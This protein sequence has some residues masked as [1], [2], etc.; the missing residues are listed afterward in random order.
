[1][2]FS[3]DF[4]RTKAAKVGSV[5]TLAGQNEIPYLSSLPRN[6]QS[7]FIR[8]GARR[9]GPVTTVAFLERKAFVE[10]QELCICLSAR[11]FSW[12]NRR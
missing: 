12:I 8:P 11:S 9:V 1:M 4:S 5:S 10:R 3:L 2:C 7:L 6:G